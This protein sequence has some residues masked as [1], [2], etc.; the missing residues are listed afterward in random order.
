VVSWLLRSL[1]IQATAASVREGQKPSS[2][3]RSD[4]RHLEC[5]AASN[6]CQPCYFGPVRFGAGK[7][8]ALV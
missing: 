3:R 2:T 4:E 5:R 1:L 7:A 8:N 6:A